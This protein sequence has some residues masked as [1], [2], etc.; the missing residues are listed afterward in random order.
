MEIAVKRKIAPAF[1]PQ[2]G[3]GYVRILT[4]RD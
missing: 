1:E 3:S 2:N 4:M